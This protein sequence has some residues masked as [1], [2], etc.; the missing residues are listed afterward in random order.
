[1]SDEAVSESTTEE[2]APPDERTR[3]LEDID[4]LES[5]MKSLLVE[6]PFYQDYLLRPETD[7]GI[8]IFIPL[9]SLREVLGQVTR[10]LERD[11]A[12]M[13]ASIARLCAAPADAP[14]AN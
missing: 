14:Q 3:Q 2:L 9:Q 11:T 8:T 4:A 10:I 7:M 13:K 12:A 5:S 1:V 6:L